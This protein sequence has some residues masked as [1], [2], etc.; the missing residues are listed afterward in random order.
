MQ[1]PNIPDEFVRHFIRGCWDGDGTVYIDKQIR[2][3]SAG[4]V[5]GSRAF[6]EAMVEKLVNA[7]LP[8]R[9]IYHHNHTKTTCYFRFTGSQ[10][11]MLYHYLYDN[12]TEAQYL[13]R[14]FD[15]FRLS[16][17]MNAKN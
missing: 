14:K 9:T 17:E 7:G 6:L 4:F 10:V 8:D 12:V 11:L 3:I 5:S 1:F 2:K 15:L 16:L 13:N